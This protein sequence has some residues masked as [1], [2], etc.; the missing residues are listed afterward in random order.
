MKIEKIYYVL[1][2]VINNEFVYLT[3]EYTFLNDIRYA[4]KLND[5]ITA[6]YIKDSYED[7][8]EEQFGYKTGVYE[9]N[10]VIIPV[11]ITY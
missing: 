3:E 6:S 2:K 10:L 7:N 11:K 9:S 5:E 8:I 4:L 1:V